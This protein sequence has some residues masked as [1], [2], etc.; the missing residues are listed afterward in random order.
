MLGICSRPKVLNLTLIKAEQSP[1][2][3]Q[4]RCT[5][6]TRNFQ[7]PRQVHLT[8]GQSTT[9]VSQLTHKD[10]AFVWGKPQE[11]ASDKLKS[12]ITSA[13]MLAYFDNSKEIVSSGVCQ[14]WKKRK[15]W[16]TSPTIT[17]LPWRWSFS[18]HTK[19]RTRER[20]EYWQKFSF[21]LVSSS[22]LFVFSLL[23]IGKYLEDKE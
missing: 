21:I 6:N 12:D 20:K 13:P 8:Q 3:W 4:R 9:A 14:F 17:W 15:Q 16:S 22:L 11:K 10:V 2:F 23:W 18:K 19:W 1:S 7:L 5:S